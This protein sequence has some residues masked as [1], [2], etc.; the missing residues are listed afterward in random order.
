MFHYRL[1]VVGLLPLCHFL[2]AGLRDNTFPLVL[3]RP[4]LTAWVARWRAQNSYLPSH[5][6]Q[7]NVPRSKIDVH[8]FIAEEHKLRN[9][10]NIGPL[11]HRG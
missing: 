5:R 11:G 9:R 1:R 7:T 8:M 2:V 10:M 4:L 3:D 6:K